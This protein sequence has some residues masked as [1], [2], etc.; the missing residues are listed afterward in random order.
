MSGLLWAVGG[1]LGF[2]ALAVTITLALMARRKP[3]ALDAEP[4]W[5]S[6]D[7]DDRERWL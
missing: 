3:Q 5:E 1:A 6:G 2:L 7:C 4:L